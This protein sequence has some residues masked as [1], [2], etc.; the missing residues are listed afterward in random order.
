MKGSSR[1][2]DYTCSIFSYFLCVLFAVLLCVFN[3]MSKLLKA[4][5]GGGPGGIFNI[6][7]STATLVNA[8][9]VCIVLFLHILLPLPSEWFPPLFLYF[10][11]VLQAVKT[12]FKDV[13]GCDEA[14]AE[15]QEFVRFLKEPSR[16]KKLGAKIPKGALLVGPPGTGKTLVS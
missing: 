4:V 13:A 5:E 14:K 15:I 11:R 6:G 8:E 2:V 1:M 10:K 3:V 7:K 16:Y 9:M 12:K